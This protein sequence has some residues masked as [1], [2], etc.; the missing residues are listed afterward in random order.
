MKFY[1][2]VTTK[3]TCAVGTKNE[4]KAFGKF[5][6]LNESLPKTPQRKVIHSQKGTAI[7]IY[8]FFFSAIEKIT[9][10]CAFAKL[11]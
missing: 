3:L 4:L 11:S 5:H 2:Y 10:A 1:K 7:V 8:S 6:I 9:G